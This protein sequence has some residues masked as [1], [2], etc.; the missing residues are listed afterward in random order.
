MPA[1]TQKP[2]FLIILA[3]DLGFSDI[4]CFGGE[5]PTPNLDALANEGML[6]SGTDNHLAGL[7][8]MAETISRQ[9]VFQG[10][11]GYEGMLNQRVA[12]LSEVMRDAGYD[13][14]MSGK[15]HLGMTEDSLPH[16]RGFDKVFSLLP[17]GG[18]HY[19]YEPMLE[20]GSPVV[21]ILPPI[22]V[23]NGDF[24]DHRT[25]PKPFYSTTYFTE[26][27][28]GYLDERD[29]DKPFFAYLPYTA[30]HWP[31]QAPEEVVAKYRGRY[32]DGPDALRER[33][34]GGLKREGIVEENVTAHPIC[35]TGDHSPWSEM[36]EDE[37]KD[38]ARRMEVYAAMIEIMDAEIGQVVAWLKESGQYDNT[39]IFFASDNGA[40]GT[41]M[42][43]LP[44]LGEDFQANIKKY[45]D[46]SL[47]NIGRANSFT[48]I[49][50]AWAQAATAPNRMY[51]AW[52]TEGGI[53]CPAIVRYPGFRNGTIS[54]EFA[55]V[56]D[57]MPTVLVMAQVQHPSPEFHGR[58]VLP[59]RG[60]S[61]LEYMTGSR[62]YVHAENAVHGWELFGQSA[63]R[64]GSWKAVWIPSDDAKWSLYNLA[65]DA[66]ETKDL[67][68]EE[69]DRLVEMVRLWR[70]YEAETGIVRLDPDQ[71]FALRG[72]GFY[73]GTTKTAAA[74]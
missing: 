59:M 5:I 1:L 10:R 42:E 53:R 73:R 58:K 71:A 15:W 19:G 28:L 2:N 38:S 8:Q 12:A 37:R 67:A 22:Y 30:P 46:N 20:D 55:T 31:L 39:F 56:M 65:T 14:F 47:D 62:D 21:K 74:A 69:P 33:R 4:G 13:T 72:Y 57:I 3:D 63:I 34:L 35:S 60:K 44:I 6:F 9:K 36:S 17:G 43:A 24:I 51:K 25:I 32:D 7:G 61:W 26:R 41:M 27:M 40:E 18:N 11:P 23:E 54:H 45:F 50:P 16:A 49:G 52:I 48:S 29:S 64:Q 70:D 68:D 66:G